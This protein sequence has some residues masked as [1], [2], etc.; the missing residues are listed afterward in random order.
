VLTRAD[1]EIV[2]SPIFE[3]RD[4]HYKPDRMDEYREWAHDAA[5]VLG[6][7]LDVLGFWVDDGI[8]AEVTG[9][10]PMDLRH[11]P[12]NVTRMIRWDSM[13]HRERG[14]DALWQDPV[15]NETWARHP[16]FEGYLHMSV[17]F[18]RAA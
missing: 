6:E 10:D 4:Y 11:G 14:W 7:R 1:P 15:W 9:S 17:R 8:P 5:L 3:I 2:A 16:G 13:E 18:L 12:A